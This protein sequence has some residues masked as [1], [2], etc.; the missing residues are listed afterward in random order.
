[1]LNPVETLTE[2]R[3][4]LAHIHANG[5]IFRSNHASNYL[6]LAGDLQPDKPRLLAEIDAALSDPTSPSIRPEHFRRL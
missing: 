2:C 1:M 5:I 4:L 6:S 3:H